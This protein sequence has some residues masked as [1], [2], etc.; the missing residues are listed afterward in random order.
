MPLSPASLSAGCQRALSGALAALGRVGGVISR[1]LERLFRPA[2]TATQSFYLFC[3]RLYPPAIRWALT[4]R[5]KVLG[6]AL[7]LFLATML[8]VPQLGSELVPQISQG[9]FNIDLRLA[10]GTPLEVTDQAVSRVQLSSEQLPDLALSYAVAGTGNRLDANPVDCR[11]EHGPSQHH[12]RTRRDRE[13]EERAIAQLRG[14]LAADAR[15]AA[16]VQPSQPVRALDAARSRDHRIRPRAPGPGRG[17]CA[18]AHARQRRCSAT[19][20]RP[21]KPAI[22]RS[23]SC[24]TRSVR[25]SSASRFATSPIESCRACAAKSRRA[26]D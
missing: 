18:H 19:C 25:R 24:S 8:I 26:T 7:V 22:P 16:S 13:D 1:T 14:S 12:S 20:A 11:R 4:H 3:E 5:I 6:G 21:S 10:A 9:E 23:R 2:V 15:R 17:T